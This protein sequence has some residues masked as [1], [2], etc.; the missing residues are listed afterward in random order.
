MRLPLLLTPLLLGLTTVI[1]GQEAQSD[2]HDTDAAAYN[3]IVESKLKQTY[4]ATAM[5]MLSECGNIRQ[6]ICIDI[7]CGTGRLDVEL[8]RRSELQIIGLDLDPEMKPYFDKNVRDAGLAKQIRFVVG[9]AQQLPFPDNYADVIVSRGVLIFIPDLAQ[10]LKEVQRV[11]KPTGVAFLGGRYLYAPAENKMTTEQLKKVVVQSGIENARVIDQRGQWV[12]ILGPQ[13]PPAARS[14]GTGPAML[15]ARCLADY[16][17]TR[18]DCLLICGNDG[19]SVQQ[20]QGSFLQ[21]T[22]LRLVAMYPRQSVADQAQARLRAADGNERIVARV[23]SIERLPF[24]DASYDLVVGVG[25]VL[26]WSERQQAMRE[27]YRVLRPGGRALVGG[28]YLQ[29]P[30]GRKVS[31]DTLRA[32]ARATDIPSIRIIDDMGQWVEVSKAKSE[33]AAASSDSR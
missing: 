21:L 30:A 12:K 25:P 33:S 14:G 16:G 31:S 3:R 7:G 24:P 29:M 5:R 23:G 1:H 20:L 26:I 28:R 4:P 10:C 8:A 11:L 19:E 6:G 2:H 17:I 27:L 32:D 9:D 18:G 15:A 13:A 22:Q